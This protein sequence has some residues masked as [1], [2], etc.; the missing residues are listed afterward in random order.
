MTARRIAVAGTLCLLVAAAVVVPTAA[1]GLD[2]LFGP[3]YGPG[4]TAAVTLAL[5]AVAAAVLGGALF[6]LRRRRRA[7]WMLLLASAWIA[8]VAVAVGWSNLWPVVPASKATTVDFRGTSAR[9]VALATGFVHACAVLDDG[10]VWCWGSNSGGQLDTLGPAWR[11]SA[12]ARASASPVP[13]VAGATA[14]A[15]SGHLTCAFAG[16]RVVCWGGAPMSL[17]QSCRYEVSPE[18]AATCE[19]GVSELPGE[20]LYASAFS[21]DLE[22]VIPYHCQPTGPE[23]WPCAPL[24]PA[25]TGATSL[26]MADD[27]ACVVAGGRVWCWGVDSVGQLGDGAAPDT[28]GIDGN[29]PDWGGSVN[30]I[31][32][33][34]AVST[35]T[36]ATCATVAGPA[37]AKRIECWG[38]GAYEALGL[39][40][41]RDASVPFEVPADASPAAFPVDPWRLCSPDPGAADAP[42][43]CDRFVRAAPLINGGQLNT[44]VPAGVPEP[45]TSVASTG[46]SSCAVA[47]GT[48]WCW[49]I[50]FGGP[51]GVIDQL[52]TPHAAPGLRGVTSIAPGGTFTCAIADGAVRCWGLA[53]SGQ[54]GAPDPAGPADVLAVVAWLA[55]AVVAG[56][57][58]YAAVTGFQG[59]SRRSASVAFGRDARIRVLRASAIRLALA[60]A[61]TVA[62][63]LWYHVSRGETALYRYPFGVAVAAGAG[64]VLAIAQ[65][66][67]ARGVR[68]RASLAVSGVACAGAA[69]VVL[70]LSLPTLLGVF[71]GSLPQPVAASPLV[72]TALAVPLALVGLVAFYAPPMDPLVARDFRSEWDQAGSARC[73]LA[74]LLHPWRFFA[75]RAAEGER[76]RLAAELHAGVLPGLHRSLKEVEDGGSVDR[77]AVDLREA[78]AEVEGMLARRRSIVLEEVG[79]LAAIE[80]LAERTEERSTLTVEIDVD[81]PTGD[82]RPPRSVERAAFRVAQLALDNCARHAVGSTVTVHV[83]V[84]PTRVS[85]AV[86]DDGPGLA[87]TPTDAVRSGRNGLADMEA[88][89]RSCGGRL[90]VTSGDP[91]SERPGTTVSFDWRA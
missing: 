70:W 65:D 28:A 11:D 13:G 60:A 26:S 43:G 3:V 39:P 33:A 46:G 67:R 15:A 84:S 7:S 23:L 16:G 80:W 10:T 86:C 54:L 82:A 42:A 12:A 68:R 36:R 40:V 18:W 81:G 56:A 64:A 29:S 2:S 31:D 78:V 62:V 38:A 25:V 47:A 58:A 87:Q 48:V 66:A 41:P 51:A 35:G 57:A 19:G 21:T 5:V 73:R 24:P 32:G 1:V 50:D 85:L 4:L 34:L 45:V 30:G 61:A 9:P 71:R 79:V 22:Q 17:Y 49:G 55:L 63:Y 72:A 52:F 53:S 76:V 75:A 27:H 83:G 20:G 44:Q 90:A 91:S 77:L 6:L 8:A 14:V 59:E 88:V 69:L 37:G 74:L 89:A